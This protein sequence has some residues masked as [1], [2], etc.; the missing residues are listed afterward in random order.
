MGLRCRS[1]RLQPC[2]WNLQPDPKLTSKHTEAE[3]VAV[4]V[5]AHGNKIPAHVPTSQ[6]PAKAADTCMVFR[7]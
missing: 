4:K 7:G 3:E 5:T 2:V 6:P 1:H